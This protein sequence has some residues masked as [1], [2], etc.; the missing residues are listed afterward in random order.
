MFNI[1]K[2]KFSHIFQYTISL[3][4]ITL[5]SIACFSA[6]GIIGYKVVALL[7]LVAVSLLAMLFDILPVLFA[8]LLSAF[9]WN[10]FFIPPI[11]TFHIADTEDA[12]MFLMYF[13][14]AL[15]NIVLTS[16]I[17]E[18]EK[19]ARDKEEKEKTIKLYN[20]LLNSLSHE[21]RTPIA[22]IIGAVDT[23]KENRDKLSSS[24]QDELLSEIDIATIRLNRQVN[25][26]LNMSRLET[27]SIK[28]NLDWCDIN[29]LIH[30]I[31]QKLTDANDK[32]DIHY[33]A[34]ETLPLFKIDVGLTEQIL[35]N[36]L[37]NAIQYTPDD[38]TITIK[39]FY[40][41]DHCIISVSDNGSGFPENEIKNVFDKFYRLPNTKTGGTGLGLS[42]AK[43]FTEAHGGK[44]SLE[45]IESGGAKFTIT[46]PAETS[47]IN[48]LKNE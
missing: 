17:R 12:L 23:L 2:K 41:H 48:N 31:V 33:S 14:I 40:E 13:L 24:H 29:E 19:K 32:H 7:L 45:N 11:Y 25:N 30:S 21:L 4:L 20:T 34:D 36:I 5:I 38:S 35:H 10:F 39:A 8:A 16:K 47:F 42:I 43:G 9:I 37:Y 26:L 3:L 28:L 15:V 27:G 22:T 46:I 44:L 1:G 6:T 18:A